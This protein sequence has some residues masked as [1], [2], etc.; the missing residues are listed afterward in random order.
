MVRNVCRLTVAHVLLGV[1][2]EDRLAVLCH[3]AQ[4]VGLERHKLGV[5]AGGAAAFTTVFTS[6]EWAVLMGM[7][8]GGPQVGGTAATCVGGSHVFPSVSLHL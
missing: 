2:E 7:A 5:T 1:F 6:D 3:V 8:A 4:H